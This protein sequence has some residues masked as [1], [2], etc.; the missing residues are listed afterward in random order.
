MCVCVSHVH[1]PLCT[2]CQK[3]FVVCAR[4]FYLPKP[5]NFIE[6]TSDYRGCTIV[7]VWKSLSLCMI[8]CTKYQLVYFVLNL[9]FHCRGD[10]FLHMMLTAIRQS[11]VVSAA[12]LWLAHLR[13][14]CYLLKA[15]LGAS[16]SAIPKAHISYYRC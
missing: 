11:L 1:M 2:C 3:F 15:F 16:S 8:V 5:L 9:G 12:I 13:V 6:L 14:P 4:L 10:C 7:K